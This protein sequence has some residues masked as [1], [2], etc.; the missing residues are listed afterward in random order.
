M[1]KIKKKR[2]SIFQVG[3]LRTVLQLNI[4]RDDVL[5]APVFEQKSLGDHAELRKTN[6][7]IK[8]SGVNIALNN[9]IPNRS[10]FFY[11]LFLI[12]SDYHIILLSQ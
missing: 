4:V 10:H 8:V 1:R 3:I 9:F 6:S 5:V 11:I 2:L 12:A 7:L